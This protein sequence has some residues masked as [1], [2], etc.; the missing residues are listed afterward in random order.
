M[1]IVEWFSSLPKELA[2]FLIAMIP[3]GEY[4]VAMPVGLTLYDLGFW[5]TFLLTISGSIIPGVI[6]LIIIGPIFKLAEKHSRPIHKFLHWIFDH[7]QRR[8]GK[9]FEIYK[10]LLL[11]LLVGVPIPLTGVYTGAIA[12]YVFGISFKRALPLIAA[13][14]IIGTII[15][16]GITVG[17]RNII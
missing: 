8:H 15:I 4:R 17:F 10:D 7:T 16:A 14:V 12:A 9:K 6:L 3:I 13:G 1:F 11:L 2:T 5:K